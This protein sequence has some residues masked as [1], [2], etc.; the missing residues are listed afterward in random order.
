MASETESDAAARL[1]A[2]LERISRL[3]RPATPPEAASGQ[4]SDAGQPSRA[5]LAA[6]LDRII[7]RLR[8]EL[9]Q[10]S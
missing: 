10:G 1:E 2:A 7:E 3:A 9:D 6:R 4:N 5:A 8:A